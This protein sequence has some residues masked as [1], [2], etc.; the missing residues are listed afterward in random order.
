L[1]SERDSLNRSQPMPYL[2]SGLDITES[3]ATRNWTYHNNLVCIKENFKAG[4]HENSIS[5]VFETPL[6]HILISCE[7]RYLQGITKIDWPEKP[8]I[9]PSMIAFDK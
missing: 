8:T 2:R 7:N 5:I 1:K 6:C 9:G 3:P 4:C